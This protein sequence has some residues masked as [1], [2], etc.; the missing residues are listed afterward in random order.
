MTM[1][2]L[3]SHQ[4]SGSHFL[5]DTLECHNS[6]LQESDLSLPRY[7]GLPEVLLPDLDRNHPNAA[8]WSF[9]RYLRDRV[10]QAPETWGDPEGIATAALQFFDEL[11]EQSQSETLLVDV[12]LNQLH[13]AEGW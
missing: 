9:A 5:K 10:A 7:R 12:K 3:L 4:R 2:F 11:E 8:K 6:H 1:V 13:I